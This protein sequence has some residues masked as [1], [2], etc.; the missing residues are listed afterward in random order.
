MWCSRAAAVALVLLVGACGFRPLFG[1]I[2]DETVTAELSTI[3]IEPIADRVGQ[4]LHNELLDRLTPEGRAQIGSY[5]L[6]IELRE[7]SQGFAIDKAEFATR[8]S[9]RVNAVYTLY[10]PYGDKALYTGRLFAV[11]S[12]N[13][14]RSEYATLI[15]QQDA[16]D[17][18]VEQL[19]NDIR[20][21]LAL[22]FIKR[23]DDK[24]PV[25]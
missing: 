19:A 23:R 20:T 13:I 17:R 14:L 15:A 1:E 2:N 5:R 18:A 8:S 16:R 10:E 7:A 22:Y 24:A 3:K 11:S 25:P 12:Y 9:Y 6:R 4:Q 21:G